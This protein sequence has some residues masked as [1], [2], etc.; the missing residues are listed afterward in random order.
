[1]LRG[2]RHDLHVTERAQRL[3]DLF[4]SVAGRAADDEHDRT[5][6]AAIVEHRSAQDRRSQTVV[7][8]VENHQG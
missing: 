4:G 1:M 6:D 5:G 7:G 8:A 3:K 2:R